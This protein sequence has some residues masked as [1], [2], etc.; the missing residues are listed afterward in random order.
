MYDLQKEETER[1]ST[2]N[3]KDLLE[4][5]KIRDKLQAA[6]GHT[7]PDTKKHMADLDYLDKS[8]MI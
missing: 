4:I 1:Y 3:F 5:A 6:E 2:T 7:W 8:E